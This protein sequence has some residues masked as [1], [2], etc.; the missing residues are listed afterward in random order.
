MQPDPSCEADSHTSSAYRF[1][2]IPPG[3]PITKQMRLHT[4][5]PYFNLPI[6]LF[7]FLPPLPTEP[8]LGPLKPFS[9]L[10]TR[11]TI[12]H[13]VFQIFYVCIHNLYPPG[14][15][16]FLNTTLFQRGCVCDTLEG[17]G[18]PQGS[19]LILFCPQSHKNPGR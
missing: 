6:L 13:L 5:A 9:R 4:R 12:F 2:K 19:P 7:F 10:K 8:R 15:P 17:H 18:A 14:V 3:P 1:N 16:L 11:R